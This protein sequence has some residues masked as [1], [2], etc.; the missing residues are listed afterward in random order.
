[1]T[2][3]VVVLDEDVPAFAE[4]L[5]IPG[6]V[7]V[8]AHFMPESVLRKVWAHF[9]SAG[10]LVGRE[11]P[12]LYRSD[13]AD[14]VARLR[15]IGVEAFSCLSYAHRPGMARW[16]TDWSLEF[17]ARTPGAIASGT[18]FPEAGAADYVGDALARGCRLFKVHVQ[19]GNFDP[20]DRMLMPVWGLLAE[21]RIPVVAH[22]GSGPVP[23]AFTGGGPFG[24][25]MAANPDLRAIIAHFGMP[26]ERDF[27][28]LLDRFEGMSLDTAMVG[29][30]FMERTHAL[31]P[32]ML[33]RV[34]ELGLSGRILFGS[35]YPNIPHPYA[36][37]V[38]ALARW[39]LGD[40]WLRAVLWH[41]GAA[42]FG[43]A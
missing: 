35:D 32:R 29:T 30:D 7:D 13:D 28:E 27:F 41:N 36:H 22:A 43:V 4:R 18:F 17:A 15:A 9:D 24:D 37:Q 42:V 40:D 23:G 5:G 12:I 2:D 31:D 21:A 1:M 39:N 25:V 33:P 11:W 20:R 26:D 8:H 34:R 16:L 38:D 10:G 19:V 6:I 14:R 3:R